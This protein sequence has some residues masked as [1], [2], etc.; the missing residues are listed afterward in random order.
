[1]RMQFDTPFDVWLRANDIRPRKLARKANVSRPTLLRMRKGS[2][3]RA[4]TRAQLVT[5]CSALIGR[6]V[7]E[8]E[9]FWTGSQ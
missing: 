8:S 5:A 4:A 9:L 7:T 2:I 1:M 3:G 6:R